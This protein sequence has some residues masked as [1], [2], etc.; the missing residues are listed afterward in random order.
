MVDPDL[1]A[2][3]GPALS[4]GLT[5]G[6][7]HVPFGIEV[8]RRGI[9]F[10]DLATAQVV[11]LGIVLA[12]TLLPPSA[13]PAEQVAVFASAFAAAAFFRAVERRLPREQEA[14]IGS[15]FVVAASAALLA[16]H[17]DP[18]GGDAPA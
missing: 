1:L 10:I 15:T 13:W 8:L 4:V 9:V 14:V 6:A 7:V 5:V 12:G 3:V 11:A 16:V 2:I 18:H 17:G